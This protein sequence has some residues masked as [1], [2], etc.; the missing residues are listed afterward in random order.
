[1]KKIYFDDIS[2]LKRRNWEKDIILLLGLALI[3]LGTFTDF[4]SEDWNKWIKASGYLL[5]SI[6]FL[7]KVFQKNYVQWDKIGMTVRINNYFREIRINFNEINYYEFIND[8][9]KIFQ[10]NKTIEL[11]LDD[12]LKSDR[13]RL[14]QIIMDNTV[15]N[16]S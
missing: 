6:Y 7:R 4:L 9:L 12:V 13:E 1:M 5:F 8:K 14:I 15:A 2:N 11:D 10:S 16:N 3:I